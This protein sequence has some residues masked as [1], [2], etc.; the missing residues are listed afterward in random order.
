MSYGIEEY[1]ALVERFAELV[2]DSVPENATIAVVSKGD[3][4]LLDIDIRT[5][6]HFPQRTDGTY[7]GYYPFDSASA[8]SH[9]ETLREKGG[10]YLAFPASALWWLEHYVELR[11]HLD[12][13]YQL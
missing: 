9:L 3:E 8:I 6:W 7:A 1:R 4:A 10:Q 11:Q 13:R 5:T 12:D 2:R